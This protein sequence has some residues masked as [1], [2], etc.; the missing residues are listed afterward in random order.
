[1][2]AKK[3]MEL[4]TS[5]HTKAEIAVMEAETANATCGRKCLSGTPP[6]ELIDARAKAEWKRIAGILE[7][8]ELVGDLDK[9]ALIG[10]CNA[11]S[12][13]RRA[14]EE[15][16]AAPLILETE[17]GSVKNPLVSVQDT[18]AKQMRDFAMKA[19]LSVDTRLKYAALKTKNDTAELEDEFGDI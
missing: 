16:A 2:G 6:L 4:H 17:R 11:F 7:P 13:Y 15:L 8:M 12:L 5:H 9:A 18:Y 3:P 10:Y 14:T 1:M 19:G